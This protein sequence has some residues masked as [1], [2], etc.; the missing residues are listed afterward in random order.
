MRTSP[1]TAFTFWFGP[2]AS[3]K[4]TLFDVIAFLGDLVSD[5]LHAAI[6]KRTRNFQDLVWGRPKTGLGF[7][8]AVEFVIPEHVKE[9]LQNR[10]D[11][12]AFRYEL[13]IE[14]TEHGIHIASER[15]LLLRQ[16]LKENLRR[17]QR[18]P[19]SQRTPD[20]ILHGGKSP[21]ARTVLQ[22]LV[23]DGCSY[24]SE[25]SRKGGWTWRTPGSPRR[26]K[27]AITEA[28]MSEHEFP[29]TSYAAFFLETFS[30]S[31]VLDSR[32]MRRAQFVK[33]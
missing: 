6:E 15:G 30:G 17:V 33:A 22:Q 12:Q 29:M 32:S 26:P 21:N 11:F 2:N 28:R 10:S 8:L 13:E 14:E 5:G 1:W 24:K 20:T 19:E 4:S 3:G 25:T 18:F 7:Q 27:A 16:P 23:R 31:V 9:H